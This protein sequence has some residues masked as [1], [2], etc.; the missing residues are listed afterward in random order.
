M[1]Y[2]GTIDWSETNEHPPSVGDGGEQSGIV[3]AGIWLN[4]PN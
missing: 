3:L 2:H 1:V 4:Q